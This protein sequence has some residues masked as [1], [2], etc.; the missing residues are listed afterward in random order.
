MLDHDVASVVRIT[1]DGID[2]NYFAIGDRADFIER[3]AVRVAMHRANVDAFVKARVNQTARRLDR[4][5]HKTVLPA[6]PR[7]AISRL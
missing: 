7:R 2:V 4:V 1:G 6:F 5:A 3:L